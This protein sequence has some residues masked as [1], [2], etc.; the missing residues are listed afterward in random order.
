MATIYVSEIMTTEPI[1][2]KMSDPLAEVIYRL[3]L[4]E[5]NALLV[6]DGK[7]HTRGIISQNH[8]LENYTSIDS[9]KAGDVMNQ[10][11]V[12]IEAGASIED[13]ARL[14]V[15]TNALRLI[16]HD[17]G[18]PEVTTGIVSASDIIRALAEEY[19]TPLP[20]RI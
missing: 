17:P 6:V 5:V 4:A 12:W 10:D 1:C 7:N 15:G 19:R 9:L 18:Q 11:L 16:V 8:I 2:C 3:T 13:A 20:V 14:M